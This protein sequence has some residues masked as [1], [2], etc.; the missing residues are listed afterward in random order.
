[1]TY[2]ANGGQL[3]AE[4]TALLRQHRIQQRLGGAGMHT[5]P[6]STTP[7]QR[8]LMGERIQRYRYATLAWCLHAVVA[9]ANPGV[10]VELTAKRSRGPSEELRHRLTQSIRMSHAG[11]PLMNEL[12][13]HEEFP[14]VESWRKIASAA[15][16]GEHD[17]PGIMNNGRMSA[18]QCRTVLRD[19]AEVTRALV[20]LDKRYERIP[21]WIPIRE[22]GRLD[23]A[24]RACALFATDDEQDYT[25]DD[26]GWR[27]PMAVIDGGPLPGIGGVLQ[28]QHNMLVHLARFPDALNL[29]RVIDGQRIL[30]HE[31]ARLARNVAPD[32]IAGWV[33]R[34]QVYES[35][36][37][38]TR[39]IGG[40]VGHGGP[41]ASEAANAVGR[42]RR[43]HVDE[44]TCAEPLQDLR[45]L[46]TRTDARVASIIEQGV[47]NRLYLIS[48]KGPRLASESTHLVR[49]PRERYVP[50]VST[51]STDLIAIIR[52]QL[53]PAPVARAAPRA[54][55]ESRNALRESLEHRP[56]ARSGPSP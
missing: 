56:G 21:G 3:R 31:A 30:S 9:A 34:E 44:I 50:V 43:L 32:L 19:A 42:L 41:A 14:L 55:P 48:V 8:E 25:V 6:V 4:L 36:L 10:N 27:P 39:N 24:A 5:V 13:T 16:L 46:S 11:L 53:R 29:R 7:E 47:A 45:K 22:R 54:T 51:D 52:Q 40:L 49:A 23:R 20:V 37:H 2:G 15:V 12:T 18:A 1:V 28:A 38:E 33:E 35:L 17:F 26:K